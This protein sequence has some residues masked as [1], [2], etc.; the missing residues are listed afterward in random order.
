VSEWTK[1]DEAEGFAWGIRARREQKVWGLAEFP[2]SFGGQYR[3]GEGLKKQVLRCDKGVHESP[4]H[5][6]PVGGA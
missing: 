1:G 4:L 3:G 5:L 6:P 2:G